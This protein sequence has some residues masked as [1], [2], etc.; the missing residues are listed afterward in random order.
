MNIKLSSVSF[1]SR[2]DI[3]A[4]G[5]EFIGEE[6]MEEAGES[7]HRLY[8]CGVC[9]IL[10]PD[11]NELRDH[12]INSHLTDAGVLEDPVAPESMCKYSYLNDTDVLEDPVAPESMCKY[13]YL[14]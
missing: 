7:T 5:E 13:S 4:E 8:R 14:R 3:M 2:E 10:S 9:G 1:N 12:M 11:V 6:V